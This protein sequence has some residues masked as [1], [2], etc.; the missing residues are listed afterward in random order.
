VLVLAGAALNTRAYDDLATLYFETF[1]VN[2][3]VLRQSE[4]EPAAAPCRLQGEGEFA[5]WP[6]YPSRPSATIAAW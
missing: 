6:T 5:A 1:H 4:R 2:P 3:F